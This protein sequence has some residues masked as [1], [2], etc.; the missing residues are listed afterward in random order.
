[1]TSRQQPE[2]PVSFRITVRYVDGA[3]TSII[4]VQRVNMRA[5]PSHQIVDGPRS[6]WWV[7]LE[8][9]EGQVVYRRVLADP[10][11]VNRE[12]MPDTVTGDFSHVGGNLEG[13]FQVVVPADST[14]IWLTVH[15]PD[16]TGIDPTASH[17][18]KREHLVRQSAAASIVQFRER[19]PPEATM[20]RERM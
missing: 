4:S 9:P 6:G 19:L 14:A 18:E 13:S 15:G 17:G 16:A 12:V 2:L 1:M 8:D 7:E 5:L 20:P 11:G 3:A 10:L